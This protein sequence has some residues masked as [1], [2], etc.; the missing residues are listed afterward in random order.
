MLLEPQEQARTEGVW[1]HRGAI[2]L[3]EEAPGN[4]TCICKAVLSQD[5]EDYVENKTSPTKPWK[6]VSPS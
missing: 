6:V 3:V 1:W 5:D 2:R 4:A